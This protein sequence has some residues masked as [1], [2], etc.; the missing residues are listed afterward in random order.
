MDQVEAAELTK[1]SWAYGFLLAALQAFL[2]TLLCYL[3]FVVELFRRREYLAGAVFATLFILVGGGWTLGVLA[4]LP[5]GWRYAKRWEIRGWILLWSVSLV[6]GLM[7]L[8]AGVMLAK[9][10]VESWLSRFSWVPVF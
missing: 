9:M 2:V 10:S 6:V 5:L 8:G 1:Q 4:A 7:N 3:R